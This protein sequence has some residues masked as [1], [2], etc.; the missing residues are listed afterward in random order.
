LFDI[1]ANCCFDNSRLSITN[2]IPYKKDTDEADAIAKNEKIL[3]DSDLNRLGFVWA[4]PHMP[5][6]VEVARKNANSFM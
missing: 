4:S 6:I 1:G 2:F 3:L 5:H